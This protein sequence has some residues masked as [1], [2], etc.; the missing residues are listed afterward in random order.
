LWWSCRQNAWSGNIYK[1]NTNSNVS[2]VNYVGGV[3]GYNY[4][5]IDASFATGVVTGQDYVGGIAGN[6]QNS[7]SINLSYFNGSVYGRDRVG[8]ALGNNDST[9]LVS[10]SYSLGTV[11]GR[12]YVGGFV[13]YNNKG[14]LSKVYSLTDV[15]GTRHYVGGLVGYVNLSGDVS[16]SYSLSSVSGLNYVGGLVGRYAVGTITNSFSTGLVSTSGVNKGGLIGQLISGSVVD[17]YYDFQTSNQS[18]TGKGVPLSTSNLKQE[19]TFSSWD[20]DSIW[21]IDN[22]VSYPS[23]LLKPYYPP[24][25]KQG[26]NYKISYLED[27]DFVRDYLDFDYILTRDL[28]FNDSSSYRSGAINLDW[29]TGSGWTS[30]GNTLN[31]FIGIFDGQ[32]YSIKNLYVNRPSTDETSLFGVVY[33]GSEVKNLKILDVNILGDDYSAFSAGVNYGV[34]RNISATGSISG[35]CTGNCNTGGIIGSINGA[36]TQGYIYDSK[37]SGS[38]FGKRY[39]V[40]GIVGNIGV[41]LYIIATLLE[42]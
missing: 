9:L 26:T 41:D 3:T 20:F 13:G 32:N 11:S 39:K 4:Q 35:E 29:T 27:L 6:N 18:D 42:L 12:D 38:V 23:L 22:G 17:S 33:Y 19:S 7:A 34:V 21:E 2:G 5:K 40:G 14:Q 16:D 31:S 8:G 36:F 28:D 24:L 37:F 30:I 1:S 25:E 15:L 10:E